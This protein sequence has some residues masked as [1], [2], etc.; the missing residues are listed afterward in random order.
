MVP[1]Q[2]PDKVNEKIAVNF[3]GDWL[4]HY[5]CETIFRPL[6]I[7]FAGKEKLF[8]LSSYSLTN[9][10]SVSKILPW[11]VHASLNTVKIEFDIGIHGSAKKTAFP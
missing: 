6:F 5:P 8:Y 9:S 7:T 3:N 1:I 10:F 11:D 2:K 4:R